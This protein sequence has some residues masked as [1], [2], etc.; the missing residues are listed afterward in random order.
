MYEKIG[1]T[2]L[3]ISIT[4]QVGL[5][6]LK[7]MLTN[8]TT[9]IS[10]HSGVG[11]S[12]FINWI[13]PELALKV[14]DVS[15]WSGKGMHTTTFAEMYDLSF[16]GRLID[17]PGIRELGLFDI[18]RQVLSHYFPEMRDLLQSCQYNNC[19]HE[20]EPGCAIKNAVQ[21]GHIH[22]DRYVNYMTILE[23]I[24]SPKY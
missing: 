20:N 21:Q 1:Y 5:E 15:G 6:Q 22:I 16:G 7:N 24:T 3:Q 11:K 18:D 8:K 23:S 12:S 2:V 19:I 14:Q 9:L 10:G 4:H 17:T 13:L